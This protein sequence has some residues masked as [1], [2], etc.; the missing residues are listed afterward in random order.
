MQIL[1]NETDEN[2][3]LTINE[4][5]VKLAAYNI[6]VERK[7]VYADIE[8]LRQ[9]G[10]DIKMQKSKTFD[11][12]I[13]S[14]TFELP[15]LKLLVDAVQASKFI[16]VKKSNELIKKLESLTSKYEAT[17]LQRQVYVSNRIKTMNESIYYNVDAIHQ[18]IAERKKICF[19]YFEYTVDKQKKFR[20]DGKYYT[21]SPVSLIWDDEN[22]YLI[23]YSSKYNGFTHYRI[24]KMN[25]IRLND[26]PLETFDQE[27]F[28]V[29]LY[30]QKIFGMFNGQEQQVTLQF[31]NSLA[32]VVI[33]RFGK[34]IHISKSDEKHFTVTLKIAISP[35]FFGW[36]FQFGTMAKVLSPESLIKDIHLQ[37]NAILHQYEQH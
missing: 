35:V 16:T 1:L 4:L 24:D 20:K 12:F 29:A 30:A 5:I 15:E 6:D 22:Y 23:S 26:E 34:D 14:R 33:D 17:Q 25:N 19:Q 11:Y 3:P 8:A 9:F 2:H 32:G 13:A 27:E 10:L 7:T 37:A 21:V 18:A 31:D 28:D 36:L